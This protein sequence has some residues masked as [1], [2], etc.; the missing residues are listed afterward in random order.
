ME[1]LLL[2]G[3][4]QVGILW[5]SKIDFFYKNHLLDWAEIWFGASGQLVDLKL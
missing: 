5:K 1:A 4:P 2:L 3:V